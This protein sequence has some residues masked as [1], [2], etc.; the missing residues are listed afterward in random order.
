[1]TGAAVEQACSGRQDPGGGDGNGEG[2][3][4]DGDAGDD[5]ESCDRLD[6]DGLLVHDA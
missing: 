2:G 5:D 4:R 6:R 1:M 3:A